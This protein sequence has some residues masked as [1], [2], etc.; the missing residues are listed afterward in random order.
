[1][2]AL[3]DRE[4]RVLRPL[5]MPSTNRLIALIATAGPILMPVIVQAD[6]ITLKCTPTYE[7]AWYE[8]YD[9]FVKLG[10][11]NKGQ[12]VELRQVR[13]S[14]INGESSMRYRIV[15]T[16]DVIWAAAVDPETGADS[17]IGS[18]RLDRQ[19]GRLSLRLLLPK[20]LLKGTDTDQWLNMELDCE[21]TKQAF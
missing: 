13:R 14:G 21:K 3:A 10:G 16:G 8:A 2:E 7:L 20:E 17:A 9:M 18:L 19:T 15:E 1:M 6:E 11:T 5:F 4:N 12:I